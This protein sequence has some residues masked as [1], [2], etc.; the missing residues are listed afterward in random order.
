[1]GKSKVDSYLK[2]MPELQLE[3]MDPDQGVYFKTYITYEKIEDRAPTVTEL[4]N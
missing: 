3:D 1:M 4:R 2:F